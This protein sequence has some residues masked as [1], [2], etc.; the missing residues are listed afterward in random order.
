MVAEARPPERDRTG[1]WCG[2]REPT[3]QARRLAT[4]Q[5]KRQVELHERAGRDG[6]AKETQSVSAQRIVDLMQ[7]NSDIIR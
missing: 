1:F 7:T 2:E 4:L 6:F 3:Q 5:V